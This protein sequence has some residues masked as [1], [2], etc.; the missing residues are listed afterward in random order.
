MFD[1]GFCE[2]F[3]ER[4]W[5]CFALFSSKMICFFDRVLMDFK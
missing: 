3:V 1:L 4:V 2:V 5:K